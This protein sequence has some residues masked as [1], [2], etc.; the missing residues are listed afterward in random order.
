MPEITYSTDVSNIDWSEMKLTLAK[1]DFDNGR[2]VQ[3][4]QRS[5]E[6]SQRCCIAFAK[7][8]IVGT[9]RALSDGVCNAYV[10]DV[11]TYSPYRRQGIATRMMEILTSEF[12]GQH[13]LLVTEVPEFYQSLDFER[14]DISLSK[15][16]GTWL[17][18][19]K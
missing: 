6:N 19:E 12:S 11:W 5:F 18:N 9:A 16:I 17:Q 10:V 7:G 3:Q 15:V 4:L 13:V 14:D 1:D 2:T 8:R